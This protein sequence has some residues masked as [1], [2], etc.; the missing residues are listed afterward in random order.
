MLVATNIVETFKGIFGD[1]AIMHASTDVLFN[2]IYPLLEAPGTNLLGVMYRCR[3]FLPYL[4]KAGV[5]HI[6]NVSSLF[7]LVGLPTKTSYCATKFGVRGFSDALRAE[8]R[9]TTVNVTCAY[10]GATAT[11]LISNSRTT[12]EAKRSEA[13][14]LD[15]RGLSPE[16]VAHQIVRAIEKNRARVLIGSDVLVVAITQ[17]L[18]PNLTNRLI[19]RLQSRLPFV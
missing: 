13:A 14:F 11:S 18:S 6:V 3:V 5:A 19:G 16:R 4:M 7:G 17:R 2:A 10:P 1:D 9:G 8:L 15:R 12:D